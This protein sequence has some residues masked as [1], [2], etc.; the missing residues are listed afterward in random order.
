MTAYQS[1]VKGHLVDQ[2]RK[3]K[4]ITDQVVLQS[5]EREFIITLALEFDYI[6]VFGAHMDNYTTFVGIKLFRPC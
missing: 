2:F 1:I 3:G 4:L 5:S 6:P